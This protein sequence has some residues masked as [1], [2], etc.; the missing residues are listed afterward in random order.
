MQTEIYNQ[1]AATLTEPVAVLNPD[2]AYAK[3]DFRTYVEFQLE[4]GYR[5]HVEGWLLDPEVSKDHTFNHAKHA[6][7]Y[8]IDRVSLAS[9]PDSDLNDWVKAH[10]WTIWY[11]Y[12]ECQR[13]AEIGKDAYRQELMRYLGKVW[14]NRSWK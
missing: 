5:W 2:P 6:A 1:I 13:I 12:Q 11:C 10:L 9:V 4:V 8:A 3:L 14:D 7:R